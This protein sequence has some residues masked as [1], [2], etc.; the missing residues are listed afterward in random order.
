MGPV[1]LLVQDIVEDIN[2]TRD[3]GKTQKREQAP[4]Q[5][6]LVQEISGKG[7]VELKI[8]SLPMS[9]GTYILSFSVHS[10]DHKVNYH[11]LDNRFPIAVESDKR[12]EGCC[13]MPTE[14]KSK[15]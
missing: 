6:P 7:Q 1:P 9:K 15:V 14:W 13:F 2:G 10:W 8:K 3:Q 11:R 5:I 4:D 12:F